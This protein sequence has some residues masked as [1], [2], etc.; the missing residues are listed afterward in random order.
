MAYGIAAG[1]IDPHTLQSYIPGQKLLEYIENPLPTENINQDKHSLEN[2]SVAIRSKYFSSVSAPTIAIAE[3]IAVKRT[4]SKT[5]A[6]SVSEEDQLSCLN[7]LTKRPVLK[8]CN[9][10]GF[11]FSQS[12]NRNANL[13][14]YYFTQKKSV[15]QK[16]KPSVK[17]QQ[18]KVD[19]GQASICN[20]FVSKK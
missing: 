11:A 14:S 12:H 2:D 8:Q 16:S 7:D 6:S 20:Y 4:Y 9:S 10:G 19:K 5:A 17:P 18:P 1:D 15:S 3:R 13:P